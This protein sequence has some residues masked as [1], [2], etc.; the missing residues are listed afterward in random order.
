MFGIQSK[1]NYFPVTFETKCW[2]K[3]WKNILQTNRLKV[4]L[5][6]L[7][8]QFEHKLVMINNVE[9]ELAVKKA[10]DKLCEKKIITGYYVVS[11][12][13]KD[14]LEYFK[15]TKDSFK[16]GYYY[17]IAELTS[18]YLCK[19]PYLLHHSGD[20]FL[21]RKVSGHWI[22]AAIENMQNDASIK[23]AN[24]VWNNDI[25]DV[26]RESTG[27]IGDFLVGQGFSD[28]QYL[29]GLNDFKQPIYSETNPLASKYPAYGGELFEK[30]VF[31]WLNNHGFKRI[32]YKKGSYIHRNF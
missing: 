27:A 15:L 1:A 16:E 10:A 6:N 22:S 29:I 7:D 23:C 11:D 19:T 31:A 30:R 20:A 3:D 21:P 12:Y 26:K 32:V 8:Y 25:N 4:L 17:S 5:H 13:E 2:E 14:V 9:D 24:L 28:Q 18:I